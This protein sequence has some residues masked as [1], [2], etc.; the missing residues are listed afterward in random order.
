MKNSDAGCPAPESLEM[1]FLSDYLRGNASFAT[2][3]RP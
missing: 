3:L 1:S 2:I